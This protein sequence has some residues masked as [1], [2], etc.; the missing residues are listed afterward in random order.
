MLLDEQVI[1]RVALDQGSCDERRFHEHV[2]VVER[3]ARKGYVGYGGRGRETW[4]APVV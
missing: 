2:L 4:Y 1:L 3:V